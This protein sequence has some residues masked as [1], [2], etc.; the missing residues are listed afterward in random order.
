[1]EKKYRDSKDTA[2]VSGQ[3]TDIPSESEEERKICDS[4]H[5]QW[6][7]HIRQRFCG[8][9]FH[10]GQRRS[11]H[12]A[13]RPPESKTAPQPWVFP[14]E[15]RSCTASSYSGSVEPGA[16]SQHGKKTESRIPAP[17]EEPLHCPRPS[18]TGSLT[19]HPLFTR[20]FRS[21]DCCIGPDGERI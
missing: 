20:E 12:S 21:C 13:H 10:R 17:T 2:L 11:P 18:E 1:M 16:T 6:N 5:D 4:A 19:G 14:A 9:M 15:V 7:P 3:I 8:T